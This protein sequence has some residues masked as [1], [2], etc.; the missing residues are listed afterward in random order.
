V[1]W[2]K[3]IMEQQEDMLGHCNNNMDTIDNT[4]L[5]NSKPW[6]RIKITV[7]ELSAHTVESISGR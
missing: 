2:K 6:I 4:M 7:L 5:R 1:P 3:K